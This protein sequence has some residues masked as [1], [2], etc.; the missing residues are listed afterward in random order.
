M[1]V[2]NV[3]SAIDRLRAPDHREKRKSRCAVAIA[4]VG[5]GKRSSI[6]E[7]EGKIA[8]EVEVADKGAVEVTAIVTS[9]F[10]IPVEAKVKSTRENKVTD[11]G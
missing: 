2:S 6:S 9:V 5:K 3:E 4:V 10:K 1:S 8:R 11:K 7:R